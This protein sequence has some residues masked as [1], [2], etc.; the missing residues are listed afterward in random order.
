MGYRWTKQP[1]GQFVDGHER[2]D[3]VGYRQNTFLPV[4]A[5][6]ESRLHS[7]KN[8]LE[9]E[10]KPWPHDIDD[11]PQPFHDHTMVWYHDESTFY[12]NDR[13]NVG[14]VHK[15]AK[16][17]PYTKGDGPSLMVADFVSAD[18]G[19]LCSPDKAESA[20]VL[21]KAGASREGY[22]MNEDILD[23]A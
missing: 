13:R 15:D 9:E 11:G 10:F 4:M 2:E 1:S 20:R 6:L 17:V 21:C 14:W 16:A 3:V 5:E 23:H 8:G 12:A 7:W 19:W 22:F 18:Y